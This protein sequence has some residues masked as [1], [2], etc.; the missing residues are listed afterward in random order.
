MDYLK[1]G[2]GSFKKYIPII[3]YVCLAGIFTGLIQYFSNFTF[4]EPVFIAI[5]A[6]INYILKAGL[7]WATTQAGQTEG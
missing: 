3:L 4:S 7:T 6:I 1:A 5:M 2:L